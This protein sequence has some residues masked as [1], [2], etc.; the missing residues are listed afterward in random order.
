MWYEFDLN[1]HTMCEGILWYRS[2]SK[3]LK[4][5]YERAEKVRQSMG[6]SKVPLRPDIAILRGGE[7]CDELI[8]GFEMAAIIECK[9]WDYEYWSKDVYSQIIPYKE[10]FQ[11]EAMILA[12]LKRIPDH[13]KTRLTKLGITV[14]D[15]V[16]P[17]GEGV[18]ELLQFVKSLAG[19]L[20]AQILKQEVQ[21]VKN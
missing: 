3:I 7:I 11:P 1:P 8:E 19:W 15:E 14:V 4:E 13:V 10:I 17:G 12:S 20:K 16:Y 9:N 5:L 18:E 6:L 21:A 2:A